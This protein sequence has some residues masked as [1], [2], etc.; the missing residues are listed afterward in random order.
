MSSCIPYI[1]LFIISCWAILSSCQQKTP[2]WSEEIA[3]IVYKNC[4]VCHRPGEAGPFPLLSYRDV[5]KRARTIAR[6]VSSRRMPPWPADPEYSHFLNERILSTEE[7]DLITQWVAAGALQ[8]DS[9]LAPP[10]PIFSPYSALGKPDLVIQ[11]PKPFLIPG[12]NQ[13]HFVA[14]KFPFEL[15]HK[16]WV[17]AIEF[18]PGNRQAVHHMNGH[19]LSFEPG[20][21]SNLYEGDYEVE[22]AYFSL[23]ALT[24]RKLGIL[25]DDLSYPQMSPSVINYLPGVFFLK[26]PEEIGGYIFP[27]KGALYIKNMHYGPSPKDT[28]DQSRFHIYFSKTP[29]KR[30]VQELILGTLG[31]SPVEPPLVVPAGKIKKF[32]SRYKVPQDMSLLT[33]NPHM[34]LIGKRFLGYA[35]GPE[36]DTIRL[37]HIPEWD[38]RWQYFYTFP[39]MVKIP[40]GYTLVAE[41]EFDNTAKNPNNP[42]DPPQEIREQNGSMRT[43]DEMFQFII[44]WLPYQEGDESVSLAP[45]E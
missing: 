44:T 31:Q 14:M 39:K 24:H 30:P 1:N 3:P 7:I 43:T 20:K 6:M 18:I 2:T 29:P 38:F 42:F 45:E 4:S 8:G 11:N 32:I 23:P 13:D 22:E 35:L 19:L 17:R 15:P 36:G 37:I 5:A 34:H 33:L 9:T 10:P 25:Q 40:K 16:T 12:D 26:Y 21:K 41:G 28:F 27:E